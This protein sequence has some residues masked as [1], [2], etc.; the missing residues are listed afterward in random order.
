M[1]P[2]RRAIFA[3]DQFMPTTWDTARDKARFAD[4]FVRF[5][6]RGFQKSDFPKWFYRQL[7][8]T[9]GHIAHY[10]QHGF[11]SEFFEN[12]KGKVEFVKQT[13]EWPCWG[14]P[15]FTYSDV[16][17]ALKAW[18]RMSDIPQQVEHARRQALEK[19]E[20]AMLQHLKTKYEHHEEPA[21]ACATT[22]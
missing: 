2:Y 6:T 16:E 1:S 18:L 17:C 13:L 4:Q 15:Q 22:T 5:V 21:E 11:F 10:N 9:F 12:D 19:A 7:S 3:P 20:R 8:N 14:D